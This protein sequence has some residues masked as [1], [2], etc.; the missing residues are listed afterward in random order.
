MPHDRR[1]RRTSLI[2]I[3]VVCSAVP[4]GCLRSSNL[5]PDSGPLPELSPAGEPQAG[6]RTVTAPTPA[7]AQEPVPPL[8]ELPPLVQP[9]RPAQPG[10]PSLN[11][12]DPTAIQTVAPQG[13]A[14]PVVVTPAPANTEAAIEPQ[15]AT[16]PA[17]SGD[18]PKP[19]APPAST[20]LLDAEIR[21]VE[22]VTRQ[23]S[24]SLHASDPSELPA[25]PSIAA[26]ARPILDLEAAKAPEP[27]STVGV[28][29][30][31]KP[32][33]VDEVESPGEPA[34]LP[35]LFAPAPAERSPS[36]PS[37][38]APV[39]GDAK[40]APPAEMTGPETADDPRPDPSKDEEREAKED[41]S[42]GRIGD[43]ARADE[44][45][46]A[47][48]PATQERPPLEIAELRLCGK[49][50]GFGSF[51][52][53]DPTALKPG[54]ILLVYWEMTGLEYEAR[55][56]AFVTRLSSHV[57]LRPDR[58]GPIAWEQA[59]PNAVDV[60]HRRRRDNYVNSRIKLPRSLEPGS[61]RLRLI[62]TD[63]VAGRT[64]SAEIPLTIAP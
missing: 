20:P 19:E 27:A 44:G 62:Q 38:P 59:L 37:M 32:A 46:P 33:R 28:T 49:V 60:C 30:T 2:M 11:T 58:G 5:R 18:A 36:G 48:A 17:Q 12:T 10:A 3:G 56:D 25:P 40:S 39:A 57:E 34:P 26:P 4:I 53:L 21:R 6:A 14:P 42:I 1:T 54:Q 50:F 63:L 22:D 64:A 15:P 43:P 23:H 61:Y 52:P 45:V 51:E 13:V 9:P 55:G 7:P 31:P 29:P 41:N 24:E 35:I 8:P 47:S 16:V